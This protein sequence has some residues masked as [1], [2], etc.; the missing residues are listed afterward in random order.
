MDNKAYEEPKTL[1]D[2]LM[3]GRKQNTL[4][5]F[6]YT[7]LVALLC[8]LT[9]IVTKLVSDSKDV[10]RYTQN[11]FRCLAAATSLGIIC[12]ATGKSIRL[13]MRRVKPALAFGGGDWVFLWGFVKCLIYISVLQYSALA[14]ALGPI[15][16]SLMSYWMIGEELEKYKIFVLVRN[17]LFVPL[18]VNPFAGGEFDLANFLWGL[19]W[20]LVAEIGGG[21]MRVVQRT[22]DHMSGL[23]LTFW[24]YFINTLLWMPPGCIPPKL[25]VPFLWPEVVQDQYDVW[26]IPPF[27]WVVMCLSGVFGGLIMVTQGLALENLDVGTY[28]MTFTPLVLVLSIL[29]GAFSHNLGL[30]VWIGITLQV[31]G[32]AT[33]LYL[34]RGQM[35]K[36]DK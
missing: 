19:L 26:A 29:Y 14:S 35:A 25:R 5:G 1:E 28:S 9:V 17:A 33:D 8:L 7:F 31:I 16:A 22:N 24:G 34:E 18:I 6:A 27:T 3:G 21:L 30:M 13:P 23:T 32:L 12:L 4:L 11:F 2:P 20:V 36:A 10:P 15:V